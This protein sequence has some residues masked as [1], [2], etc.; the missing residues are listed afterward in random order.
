MRKRRDIR[1]LYVPEEFAPVWND[2]VVICE[3]EGE[4]AS[5][6]IRRMVSRYVLIHKEGNPQTQLAK[7][8]EES[9]KTCYGCEGK[10]PVLKKVR[11]ISGL[12]A[13]VCEDCLNE[14]RE[15]TVVKKVLGPA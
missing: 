7:F 5:E 12:V 3:R 6:K 8:T 13:A 9:M 10:F 14:Y 11:F 1:N 4:S 2:F 15:R